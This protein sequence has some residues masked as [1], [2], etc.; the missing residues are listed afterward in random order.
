MPEASAT[1]AAALSVVTISLRER[2]M[3]GRTR[4]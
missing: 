4:H 3:A 2:G 1:T